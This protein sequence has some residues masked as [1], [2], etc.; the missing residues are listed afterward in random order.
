MKAKTWNLLA[1]GCT[2]AVLSVWGGITMFIDPFLHYHKGQDFL[3]Y[4][5]RDER[6]QNDGIAR[7]YDYDS[8]ITGTSMCQNFKCSEF[9]RLWG[10]Q[11]IKIANSGATYHESGEN[12]RRALS[13]QPNVAYVLCSLDGSRLNEPASR[14]EYEGYPVYLYDN[15]PFND[16]N[17]LLNKEVMPKTIAVLNYT[18]SGQKTPDMDEYQNWSRYKTFGREVVLAS[19][20]LAQEREEEIV[21]TEEDVRQIREN[22]GDNFLE[23]AKEHPDTTF[24]FFFPPYS[25]CYWEALVRTKQLDSQLEAQKTGAEVLLSAENVRVY[26]FSYRVDI[27]GDLDNY[28]DSLHYGE[29]INSE[30]LRMMSAGEGLLTG[31]NIE[32]Y[33]DSVRELYAGYDY[34]SYKTV[35]E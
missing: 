10:A 8:I 18:R 32:E 16:V 20:T 17:Y 7:H 22:V 13:Y 31:E 6:Y 33:Y 14:D 34:S 15:N 24:Y 27:I 28:T 25:I 4:P 23:L 5:L 30:M 1:I 35:A 26:D 21:L 11:A 29:W 9:D 19:F 2:V 12:I 3:E